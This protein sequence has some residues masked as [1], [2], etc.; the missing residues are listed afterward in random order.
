MDYNKLTKAELIEKLNEQKHLASAVEAKDKE[1]LKIKDRQQKIVKDYES[2]INDLKKGRNEVSKEHEIRVNELKKEI[3]EKD[4]A[5]SVAITPETHKE[6]L[7]KVWDEAQKTV[8][9]ANL[10]LQTYSQALSLINSAMSL[11]NQNDKYMSEK[12][13]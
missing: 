12:I 8:D 2:R 3:L 1:I 6:E 7:E 11:I 5:L 13:K 9:K 4:R 10:V